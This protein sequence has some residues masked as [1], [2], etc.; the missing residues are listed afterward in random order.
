MELRDYQKDAVES[1]V[2]GV[3]RDRKIRIEIPVGLGRFYIMAAAVV[4][5]IKRGMKV[6]VLLPDKNKCFQLKD[7][8]VEEEKN[9]KCALTFKQY[10][11]QELLLATY[12]DFQE[13]TQIL[14]FDL[15]VCDGIH[16]GNRDGKLNQLYKN[17]N[18]HFVG[19]TSQV[20]K[21]ITDFFHE[22]RCVFRYTLE[23]AINAGY[24]INGYG[25]MAIVFKIFQKLGY[26]V[27]I[28]AEAQVAI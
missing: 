27:L 26:E 28:T 9:I 7:L 23:E 13:Q 25:F 2:I 8:C 18:T 3:E 21:E 19:F 11:A 17:G 10:E 15:I 1:I 5:C 12:K 22:S 20:N 24:I 16:W 4:K 6:L 14:D